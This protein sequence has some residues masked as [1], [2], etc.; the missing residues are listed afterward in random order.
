[1]TR[2]YNR[3]NRT[4][5]VGPIKRL[6][7]FLSVVTVSLG[8]AGLPGRPAIAQNFAV[9]SE[10]DIVDANPGDGVCAAIDGGC[11]LR[12]AVQE[13]NALPGHQ[14]V[15]LPPGKFVLRLDGPV[16][17]AAVTGDLDITDDLTITG[18]GASQ[19][20]ITE[21]AFA[22]D[23]IFDVREEAVVVM[24]HLTIQGVFMSQILPPVEDCG[25]AIRNFGSL[26]AFS[27]AIRNNT[28]RRAGGGVCSHGMLRL[29][30]SVIEGNIAAITGPGGGVLNTRGG[31]AILE[32]L[33][34]SSN[35]ADTTGGGGVS[36]FGVMI[37]RDSTIT[38][39]STDGHADGAGGIDNRIGSLTIVNT[40][41]S[42]NQIDSSRGAGLTN[43][44]AGTVTVI[45]STIAGN[46]STLSGGGIS[47]DEG[48][49]T[50]LV[51]TI[52]ADNEPSN[53]KQLV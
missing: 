42:G 32:R 46:F 50:E 4:E 3:S 51:N 44:D 22:V 14:T 52:V 35:R 43:Q 31:F 21:D 45:N 9:N 7:F 49:T 38:A 34:V 29:S 16:E 20:A 25:G 13:A 28:F 10:A 53:C 2:Q 39:N 8:L 41:V 33:T 5:G 27:L 40:T 6:L 36:N 26:T 12:A 19:T 48:S 23:R 15:V 11:T 18:A 1:L 47:T 24:S 30:D 37:L 17:D